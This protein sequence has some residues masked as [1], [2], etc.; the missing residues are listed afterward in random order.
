MHCLVVDVGAQSCCDIEAIANGFT[1]LAEMLLF[2]GN[3]MLGS[4]DNTSALYTFNSGSDQ[5]TCEIRI[6]TEAFLFRVSR[7]GV[8]YFPWLTY[9]VSTTFW[10]AP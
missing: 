7:Y 8:V 10:S 9:P 1:N 4:G 2:V 5:S 3:V 6:G